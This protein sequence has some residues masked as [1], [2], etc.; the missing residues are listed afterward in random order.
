M[1][2]ISITIKNYYANP[3]LYGLFSDQLTNEFGFFQMR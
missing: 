1:I 3:G 2:Q